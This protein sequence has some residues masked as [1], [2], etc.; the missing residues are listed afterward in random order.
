MKKAAIKPNI[1]IG[2]DPGTKTGVAVWSR[3]AQAFVYVGTHKIHEALK[4]VEYYCDNERAHVVFEDAR[5][6][7][8]LPSE[9]E[10]LQGAGSVKR[11]S[12]IWF[13]FLTDLSDKGKLTF[14]AVAPNGKTNALAKNKALTTSNLNLPKNTSEHARCAAFMVWKI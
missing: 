2:I 5:K 7:K 11:D 3:E 8:A 12:T 13:D 9:V 4:L 10:R 1:C 6:R 14:K